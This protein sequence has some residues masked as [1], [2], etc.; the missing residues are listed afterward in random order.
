VEKLVWEQ[1]DDDDTTS[2]AVF[3]G[4]LLVRTIVKA[5]V[6]TPDGGAIEP[7]ISVSLIFIPGKDLS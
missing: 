5:W 4:G 2:Q 7:T 3:H 1:L 6:K